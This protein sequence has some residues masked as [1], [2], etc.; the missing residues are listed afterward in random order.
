MML[1]EIVRPDQSC[2]G[3]WEIWLKLSPRKATE[4]AES[5]IVGSGSTKADAILNAVDDL[6]TITAQLLAG[7]EGPHEEFWQVPDVGNG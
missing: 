2:D 6:H 1:F 3:E 5:F 4:Q 7:V